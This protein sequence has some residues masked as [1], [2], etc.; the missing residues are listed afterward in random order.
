M[1]YTKLLKIWLR[2]LKTNKMLRAIQKKA[3]GASPIS[4]WEFLHSRPSQLN[5][6]NA[7]WDS[8]LKNGVFNNRNRAWSLKVR[9]GIRL[10]C[11]A[12]ASIFAHPF[13][14]Y[15]FLWQPLSSQ[16]YFALHPH[17]WS[18]LHIHMSTT[19]NSNKHFHYPHR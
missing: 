12:K 13:E 3:R 2:W 6:Y 14:V 16:N 10:K 5:I 8:Y 1:K 9:G 19:S 15:I 18:H 17:S 4:T 11:V 7:L